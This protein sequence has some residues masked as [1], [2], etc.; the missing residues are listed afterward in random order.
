MGGHGND[1]HDDSDRGSHFIHKMIHA[2]NAIFNS[3]GNQQANF[4][5]L[6]TMSGMMGVE[7]ETVNHTIGDHHHDL[8]ASQH[9][10]HIPH[11][12]PNNHIKHEGNTHDGHTHTAHG[13]VHHA[14]Y[15]LAEYFAHAVEMINTVAGV[16]VL[17]SVLL[18]G[19]NLLLVLS[20]ANLG[21][22]QGCRGTC[23]AEV[24]GC[25]T[26]AHG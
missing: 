3:R 14:E 16:I 11:I 23:G 24:Q 18:V 20:N 9:I 26:W 21:K 4:S 13:D 1:Q 10:P 15:Q 8:N 12:H 25:G 6:E 2:V 19:Y 22:E 7:V 17:V 5:T